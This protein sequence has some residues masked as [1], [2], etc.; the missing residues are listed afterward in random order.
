MT[1]LIRLVRT[2]GETWLRKRVSLSSLV[3]SFSRPS[4]S[5]FSMSAG[6]GFRIDRLSERDWFLLIGFYAMISPSNSRLVS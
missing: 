1:R 2:K 3:G 4:E 6:P 5:I